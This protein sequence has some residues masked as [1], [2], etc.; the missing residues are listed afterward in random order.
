MQLQWLKFW[1]I[2]ESNLKVIPICDMS[3][4]V[5]FYLCACVGYGY[6]LSV[7]VPLSWYFHCLVVTGDRRR[8][9]FLLLWW[10]KC[11][12]TS[13]SAELLSID[14]CVTCTCISSSD[15]ICSCGM[16]CALLTKYWT[17][18]SIRGF[19]NFFY[20]HLYMCVCVFWMLQ[21][22]ATLTFSVI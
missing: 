9:Y 3:A 5:R 13:L 15:V 17:L 11:G 22:G 10:Y 7:Q 4:D 18:G 1:G 16:H 6:I 8:N 20:L 12:S 21:M 2:C 19:D 14:N